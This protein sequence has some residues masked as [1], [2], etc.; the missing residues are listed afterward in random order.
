MRLKAKQSQRKV[1]GYLVVYAMLITIPQGIDIIYPTI[2]IGLVTVL[3]LYIELLDCFRVL[4][5]SVI[6]LN[7]DP[8][9]QMELELKKG[10][11]NVTLEKVYLCTDL[12][13]SF[14]V[15]NESNKS[16]S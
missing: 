2:F 10:P 13:I 8:T 7:V 12:L 15:L 3:C 1:I 9:G 16:I 14:S 5:N 11:E 4:P 6:G